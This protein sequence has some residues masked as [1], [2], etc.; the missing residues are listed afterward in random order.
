[1]GNSLTPSE[2]Q[3]RDWDMELESITW[4]T[5]YSKHEIREIADL[6]QEI[7]GKYTAEISEEDFKTGTKAVRSLKLSALAWDF[8]FKLFDLNDNGILSLKELCIS[9]STLTRGT[10]I[11]C[12]MFFWDS[13]LRKEEKPYLRKKQF[14]ARYVVSMKGYRALRRIP[15]ST[16]DADLAAQAKE[17]FDKISKD[18]KKKITRDDWEVWAKKVDKHAQIVLF[19]MKKVAR[20]FKKQG[21]TR[22][23]I[24]TQAIISS[25]KT[26]NKNSTL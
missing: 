3:R 14:I 23:Q 5:R 19:N 4:D 20:L 21:G 1:M 25:F 26:H 24:D 17:V 8:V 12:L 9:L 10:D 13:M 15:D 16:S 18:G 11:D 7:G 2:R 22:S 6:F